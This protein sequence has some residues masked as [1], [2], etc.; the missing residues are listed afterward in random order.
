MRSNRGLTKCFGF[1]NHRH[2]LQ[3][4]QS[5]LWWWLLGSG[6][7]LIS[8]RFPLGQGAKLNLGIFKFT[9][10]DDFH[11]GNPLQFHT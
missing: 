10:S 4:N 7:T 1:G 3:V 8:L 9:T 6:D 2:V 5:K 11:F